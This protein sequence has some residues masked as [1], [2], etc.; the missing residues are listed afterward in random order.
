MK[1]FGS[2]TWLFIHS[3][4]ENINYNN[5]TILSVYNICIK[6]CYIFQSNFYNNNNL[7][8]FFSKINKNNLKTKEDIKI[9]FFKFHNFINYKLNIPLFSYNNMNIYENNNIFAIYNLYYNIYI[10]NIKIIINKNQTIE[11]LKELNQ[12][13]QNNK[14]KIIK[15]INDQSIIENTIVEDVENIIVEDVKDVENTIVKDVEDVEKI[16]KVVKSNIYKNITIISDDFL[17]S[18]S[19]SLLEATIEIMKNSNCQPSHIYIER[20]KYLKQI[21]NKKNNI[22]IQKKEVVNEL[23]LPSLDLALETAILKIQNNP[24]CVPV[25]LYIKK[26]NELKLIRK[27][28]RKIIKK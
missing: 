5:I 18:S 13:I 17:P 23:F 8:I 2:S 9:L 1:I 12:F 15:K 16:I 4:I 3:L 14:F 28:N 7:S 26:W 19:L 6:I 22:I 11:L 20:W 10:K 21:Y 25:E 24:S 27:H